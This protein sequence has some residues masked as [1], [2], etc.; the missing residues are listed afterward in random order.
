MK[1]HRA[2]VG[3]VGIGLEAY[4]KQFSGLE[5]RLR[6]YVTKVAE[7]I[8]VMDVE[9]IDLGLVDTAAKGAE[10]GHRLRREDLDIL[11][12][13]AT[14]Y[15]LSSSVLPMIQRA[16]IPVL[17]LNLQPD[18][19]IDYSAFN[20][21]GDRTK[22]T[23]EW[24]AWCAT[25]PVPE[26]ANVM[27]R[28]GISVHQITGVLQ[29]DPECWN[30]IADWMSAANVV[31]ALMANRI[32]LLGHYYS[33]MLDIYTDVTALCITFGGV[34]EILEVDK[35]SALR[36]AVTQSEISM[37]VQQFQ[38]HFEVESGCA[39]KEL[40]R[41]ART[42]VALD[43][44]IAQNELTALAYYYEGT[45]VP[46]NEDTMSSIILGT[47]MLTARGVPVAGEYEVKN[48]LA[49]K[50]LDTL[51]AGGSFTEFYA[52]DFKDDV[53][54]MGHDGPGHIGIAE[55]KTLVRPLDVYH[56][57][58]GRGLSVEMS[59]RNGLVTLLSVVEDPANGKFLL[60]IAEATVEAGPRLEIGNTNSR[61][62]FSLGARGFIKEWN[63]HG[64]AHHCAV[65]VGH[66][67]AELEKVA[68][69]LNIKAVRV[70]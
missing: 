63:A 21:L 34:V 52:I 46:A 37:R 53:V 65:G 67:A 13:Y 55:G 6:S 48:V 3:L 22:M 33:G 40:E 51:G 58:V 42:S 11:V 4:W 26:I 39:S 30:E 41:A 38:T 59:V 54:L 31:A 43:R 12:I 56:G 35:L 15:A 20:A 28:A 10:V 61:F 44:L 69:L 19:A 49:M 47:S 7:K 9:V 8:S 62:R 24:L 2:R 68:A 60:L 16:R 14:T 64:P 18:R 57:K 36:D 17:L 27:R 23:G 5:Q 45:G 1:T 25:C 32:G 66:R 50:I 29:D 70:C